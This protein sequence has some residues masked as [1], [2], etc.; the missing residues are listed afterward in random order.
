MK[1][2]SLVQGEGTPL[3]ILHGLFGM[4]DNWKSLGSQWSDLFEVHLI[5]ERNH[6]RSP[7][8]PEHS[9][10]LMAADLKEYFDEHEIDRAHIIGHSMGGKTAMRFA[11]DYPE[12]VDHLIIVDIGPQFYPIHHREII[13]ALLGVDL[14]AVKSRREAEEMLAKG[15]SIP[16]IRQ[17]LLKNLYW[18]EKEK[19]AWRF[20]LI[21]INDQIAN[22][23][24]SLKNGEVYEG[25]T[26]FIAGGNSD[27]IDAGAFAHIQEHFTDAA[28][29]T[30]SGAGHWVHAEKPAELFQM[31]NS[32]ISKT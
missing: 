11:L 25:P 27:Y 24:E 7:H 21:G 19:L 3:I 12:H 30:I 26:L 20:N 29:E 17:F 31:V 10:S 18:E 15:I 4:L 28:V 1:L 6:G 32:F 14:N 13:D 22:V 9:Y 16:A 23:G 5:D 8:S 2:H